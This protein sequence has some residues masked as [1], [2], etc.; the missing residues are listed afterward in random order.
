MLKQIACVVAVVLAIGVT[1][2]RAD[3]TDTVLVRLS[4]AANCKDKSS[5]WR[6]WC[7]AAGWAKGKA[8]SLK[9]GAMAGITVAIP[10]DA[11]VKQALSD[12]VSFVVLAVRKDGKK[13]LVTLRDVT[14]DNASESEMIAKALMG[15]A[16]VLKGKAKEVVLEKD[17]RGFADGLVAEANRETTKAK[18]GWTWE[19]DDNR[20][21]LRQVG[22]AWV[23]IETPKAGGTGRFVTVLTSKVK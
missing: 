14:P 19:T 17:L 6:A 18:A 21:E 13:L 2:V 7:P 3:D 22:S 15:V 11:D 20:V 23:V 10:A 8:G 1:S 5:V 9:P 4:Q 16:A 12:K